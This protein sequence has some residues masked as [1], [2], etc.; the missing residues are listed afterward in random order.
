MRIDRPPLPKTVGVIISARRCNLRGK[1]LFFKLY[2]LREQN[3]VLQVDVPVQ[4][5]FQIF[6]TG[7]KSFIAGAGTFR[8]RIVG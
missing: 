7:V 8:S 1:D 2:R 3:I 6:E 5:G 4:V